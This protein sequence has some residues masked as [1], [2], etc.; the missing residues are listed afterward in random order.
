MAVQIFESR[1]IIK[2]H[3]LSWRTYAHHKH[4]FCKSFVVI[5]FV[6]LK[7]TGGKGFNKEEKKRNTNPIAYVR[8]SAAGER[9]VIGI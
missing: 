7:D 3:K 1:N 9:A 4:G 8:Q 6:R 2:T 5:F